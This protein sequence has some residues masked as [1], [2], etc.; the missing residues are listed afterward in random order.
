M[1]KA[2]IK[3]QPTKVT[4]GNFQPQRKKSYWELFAK[5]HPK[6]V[7][8]TISNVIAVVFSQCLLKE[9]IRGDYFM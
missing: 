6:P 4:T 1:V 8:W 9:K 7:L 3:Q 2:R 5:P